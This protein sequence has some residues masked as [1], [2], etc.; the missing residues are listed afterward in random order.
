MVIAHAIPEAAVQ[1]AVKSPSTMVGSDGGLTKGVGHPR[2]AGTF[3]RVIGHYSHELQLISLPEAIRK[4]SY[5][6]AK[7]M[8]ARCSDFRRKGR[9]Q[10]GADADIVVF[11]AKSFIDRATFDQPSLTSLGMHHVIVNGIKVIGHGQLNE[12]RPGTG[13]RSNHTV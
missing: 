13:L 7:R 4:T 5:L 2:S 9:I 11:D 12:L 8:E 1:A 6:A 3:A 10:V